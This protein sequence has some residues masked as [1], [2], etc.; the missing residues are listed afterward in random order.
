MFPP[1]KES[2]GGAEGGAAKS[3]SFQAEIK[4]LAAFLSF[5]VFCSAAFKVPFGGRIFCIWGRDG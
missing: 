3:G 2:P 4:G 1:A 5:S